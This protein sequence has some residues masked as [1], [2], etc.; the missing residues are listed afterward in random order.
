MK[1]N[2]KGII[3]PVVTPFDEKERFMPD[4]LGQIIDALI[5]QGVHAIFAI[6]SV[7]EFY[8]LD[9]SETIDVIKE[10]VRAVR[11][12]VPVLAGTGAI[13]TRRTVSLSR[14]AEEVGADALSVLTPFY[15]Q[16]NDDELLAHYSKVLQS[17]RIPVLGY[18]NPGRSG[19]V[20]IS[21]R[22]A[23]RLCDQHENFSGLKDSSGNI[24]LLK[25]YKAI[26]PAD[27]ALFTGLDTIV[28]EALLNG[29]TG[30]VCGLANIAPQILVDIYNKTIAGDLAGA[31]MQQEKVLKLRATYAFGTFPAV[32]KEAM[33]MLGLPAGC[34]RSPVGP[35]KP[36]A[37]E[38]LRQALEEV[39]EIKIGQN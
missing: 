33:N 14:H 36:E 17:V 5:G 18:T 13:D 34:T 31:R 2:L 10:T 30:G 20:T 16:P 37:R 29:A 21:T 12:R 25:E 11:G 39:L 9:E 26:C 3:V 27:F 23:R 24:V 1:T 6:G 22:L 7:G 38:R 32:V 19:G 35:L 8:A 4:A 15:I 28:Y